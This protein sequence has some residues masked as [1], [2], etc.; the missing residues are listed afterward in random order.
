M[1]TFDCEGI[2]WRFSHFSLVG[3][4]LLRACFQFSIL[5][6]QISVLLPLL[7]FF[8]CTIA[9]IYYLFSPRIP[10]LKGNSTQFFLFHHWV[11]IG[12][13]K[14]SFNRQF[15]PKRPEVGQIFIL[16]SNFDQNKDHMTSKQVR[17]P[18]KN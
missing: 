1:H 4:F 8:L 6:S 18:S 16:R 15:S 3:V 7:F 14:T 12:Q 10:I 2:L 17:G 5:C 9:F 11:R 13:T